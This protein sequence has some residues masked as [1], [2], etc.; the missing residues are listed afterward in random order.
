VRSVGE[1]ARRILADRELAETGLLDAFKALVQELPPVDRM[2]IT[3]RAGLGGEPLTLQE[4]GDT[5]GFSRERARQ[6]EAR[7]CSSMARRA[8]ADAVRKRCDDSLAGGLVP[9]EALEADPWW[10]AAVASPSTLRF[11]LESVLEAGFVLELGER[12]W[13]S[14][15]R[16]DEIEETR[17]QLWGALRALGLPVAVS[18][19]RELLASHAARLGARFA[20]ELW[21]EIEESVQIEPRGGEPHVV[22]LGTTR[23][24]EALALLRSI[25]QPMAVEELRTQLGRFKMPDEVIYFR[26]GVVGLK[27]HF[28]DFDAWAAR[29]VPKAEGVVRALGPDRQWSCAEIL[30]EL[31][32]E[33]DLPQWMTDGCLAALIK[34]G[35]KLQYLG[36]LR[37]ALPEHVK[38]DSRVFV[39]DEVERASDRGCRSH[40]PGGAHHAGARARRRLR[41]RSAASPHS[42]AVRPG[43]RPAHRAPRARR[44]RRRGRSQRGDRARRRTAQEARP[45]SV[46][47]PPPRG[48]RS[49]LSPS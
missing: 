30:D 21:G 42:P 12:L 1:H 5:L 13:L 29:L 32:E 46:G 10:S 17:R 28:P 27:Q 19:V 2:V 49:P 33:D 16:A 11:I 44:A 34:A 15:R 6:L 39:H 43:R 48:G 23:Q 45:G 9:L 3:R 20:D 14:S 41:P 25:D 37:V 47:A 31:R 22:A 18:R 35:S 24:E 7:A 4:V 26:W 8:W 38:D 36:R 40:V